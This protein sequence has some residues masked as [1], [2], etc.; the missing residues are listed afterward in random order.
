MQQA[1]E[2]PYY[3]YD[4]RF[5][6]PEAVYTPTA[7]ARPGFGRPEMPATFAVIVE[8]EALLNSMWG[9]RRVAWRAE[10]GT[11]CVILG[12]WSDGT[13][14]LSWPAIRGAYKVVGRF[15][16]WVVNEDPDAPMAAGGHILKAND[17]PVRHP[18]HKRLV[19][20]IS[21]LLRHD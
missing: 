14:R 2:T 12:Y 19:A 15:P 8:G 1:P 10:P 9:A 4:E 6:D 21:Q 18:P 3:H 5:G 13:V 20:F 11:E 7:E 16:A 17:P